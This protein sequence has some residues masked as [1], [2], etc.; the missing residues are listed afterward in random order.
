MDRANR[1]SML[2]LTA[3]LNSESGVSRYFGS[4]G[5]F[6]LMLRGL[7]KPFGGLSMIYVKIP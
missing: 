1:R 4:S 3:W 7:E 5:E 6:S 2:L